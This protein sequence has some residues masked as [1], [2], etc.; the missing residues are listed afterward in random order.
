MP[1]RCVYRRADLFEFEMIGNITACP[2]SALAKPVAH[3]SALAK[4]VAHTS[5][6]AKPVA[7]SKVA[8]PQAMCY[9]LG[10]ERQPHRKRV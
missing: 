8:L 5:A 2:K 10:M 6:L 9:F 4:P 1:L 3:T 7:H